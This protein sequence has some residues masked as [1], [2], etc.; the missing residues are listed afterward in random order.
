[1]KKA[2]EHNLIIDYM[3]ESPRIDGGGYGGLPS[4]VINN[5]SRKIQSSHGDFNKRHPCENKQGLDVLIPKRKK[6]AFPSSFSFALQNQ[7]IPVAGYLLCP[8][9]IGCS[10]FI[11]LFVPKKV[12]F[13]KLEKQKKGKRKEKGGKK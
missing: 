2:D 12:N 6:H 5:I 11:N 9:L 8:S 1:M 4:P 10:D 13:S 3:Q 7:H